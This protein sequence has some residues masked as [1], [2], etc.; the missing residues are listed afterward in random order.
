M[1]G[2]QFFCMSRSRLI[3]QSVNHTLLLPVRPKHRQ[4]LVIDF[5]E[6]VLRKLWV[7]FGFEGT[8][9]RQYLIIFFSSFKTRLK[10]QTVWKGC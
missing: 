10:F 1:G 5:T 9:K 6:L 2:F 7:C 3:Y 8:L 4:I